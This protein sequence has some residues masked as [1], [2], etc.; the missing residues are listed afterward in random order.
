MRK[1]ALVL[2]LVLL[3]TSV[4]AIPASAVEPRV[5]TAVPGITVNGT[6]ATCSLQAAAN[7]TSDY[8]EATIKLYRGSTKIATWYADGY[9]YLSFSESKTVTS[10]YTYTMK[11]D[12][13]VNGVDFPVADVSDS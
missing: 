8:L 3:M 4:L 2:A 12:L 6:T 1:T 5:T 13:T 11:V 9:G 10:G 7:S